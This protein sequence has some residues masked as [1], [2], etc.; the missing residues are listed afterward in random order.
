MA[1]FPRGYRLHFLNGSAK[2]SIGAK[3]ERMIFAEK[4]IL[5][6]DS[7][8]KE[9]G[10]QSLADIERGLYHGILPQADLAIFSTGEPLTRAWLKELGAITQQRDGAGELFM[11][12]G[13]LVRI[14]KL[15]KFSSSWQEVAL[16]H[17]D[18]VPGF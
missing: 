10:E 2:S 11:R 12:W 7:R 8:M 1:L 6:F 4:A 9:T 3:K 16:K 18:S 13:D 5:R 15:G 17:P 14:C